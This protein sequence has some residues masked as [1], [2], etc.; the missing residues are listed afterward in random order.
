VGLWLVAGCDGRV[1][2]PRSAGT[3]RAV[4]LAPSAAT[5]A[6]AKPT[7]LV[8]PAAPDRCIRPSPERPARPAPPRGPAPGCPEAPPF[9]E[10]PVAP[11]RFLDAPG[12]PITITAEVA[13]TDEERQRGLMFRTSLGDD[14]G[15][16]FVFERERQ[17]AFW[18]K[19]TC[20][21]LDMIFVASD[22]VIVGIEENVP[23]LNENTYAP[24]CPASYVI[25]VN[26]GWTRERGVRAG[27][28]VELP[29]R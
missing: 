18:M 2:E 29:P 4:E 20:I 15:M 7:E 3:A 22:G 11:V 26:A 8:P 5:S 23:T 27:Q 1:E 16:I 19:N 14:R 25:E 12:G 10:L 9:H 24:G 17:L 13:K 28:R 21:P 6:Q